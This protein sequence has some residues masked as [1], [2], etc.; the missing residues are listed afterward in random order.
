MPQETNHSNISPECEFQFHGSLERIA[1]TDP[2]GGGTL[3]AQ[4]KGSFPSIRRADVLT[5]FAFALAWDASAAH[6]ITNFWPLENSLFVE[7]FLLI[8]PFLMLGLLHKKTKVLLSKKMVVAACLLGM[9]GIATPYASAIVSGSGAVMSVLSATLI[10]S[11]QAFIMVLC[12]TRL[13]CLALSHTVLCLVGWQ[14]CLGVF[15]LADDYIPVDLFNGMCIVGSGACLLWGSGDVRGQAV[16]LSCPTG[17]PPAKEPHNR[18]SLP[19]RLFTVNGLFVFIVYALHSAMP[20]AAL[21]VSHIGTVVA[22][23][24]VIVWY[25]RA[26]PVM[27]LRTLY[28][29]A[30]VFSETAIVIFSL[31]A[32]FY[33][34]L[35][36]I[37]LDVAYVV[38]VV[39]YYGLLCNIRLRYDLNPLLLFAAANAIECAAAFLGGLIYYTPFCRDWLYLLPVLLS[40]GMVVAFA[41]FATNEDIITSWGT[42]RRPNNIIDPSTYYA[43]LVELCASIAMQYGLSRKESEILLLLAQRKTA[44]E[45]ANELFIAVGTVKTHMHNIYRKLG[46]HSKKELLELVGRGE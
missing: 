6:G 14:L 22:A 30:L 4:L 38:F 13:S 8:G 3:G 7:P 40:A 15:T 23:I 42:E 20:L 32:S 41:C 26:A 16:E 39:F 10:A 25:H 2:R 12:V 18:Y 44:P 19:M 45:I 33:M 43:T 27:R 34:A 36:A 37:L 5:V 1:G 11:F 28:T 31:G 21:H 9:V 29:M 35:S 24:A 46:I 17:R